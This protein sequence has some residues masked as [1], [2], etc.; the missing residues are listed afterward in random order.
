M[1]DLSLVKV[2]VT[3]VSLVDLNYVIFLQSEGDERVLPI[4]IGVMEAQAIMVCLS[5]QNFPRPLTHDLFTTILKKLTSSV[6]KIYINGLH[7]KTFHAR[8]FIKVTK[9]EFEFD[10]R[11]S[12][13]IALAL[14]FSAPI[15]VDKA[16][17][18]KCSINLK[19]ATREVEKQEH[20][21]QKLKEAL[22]K[23][24]ADERFE[25]AAKIRDKI[26]LIENKN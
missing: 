9:S 11:P 13:A 17:F 14:R 6:T 24:V 18:E 25:D 21:I 15:Y 10:A 5:S 26:Q 3:K 7:E 20:P 1:K 22:D 8:I 23:A 4:F 12:D 2:K 16:M 19:E